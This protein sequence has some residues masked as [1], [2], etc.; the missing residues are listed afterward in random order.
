MKL[1]PETYIRR[2]TTMIL[3]NLA[4]VEWITVDCNEPL[5]YQSFCV[6]S[7]TNT[8]SDRSLPISESDIRV[9]DRKCVIINGT[10]F[11]FL[12]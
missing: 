7:N 1:Y 4:E 6:I 2:C 10:C 3:Y 11:L 5:G 9:T 12:W 8:S